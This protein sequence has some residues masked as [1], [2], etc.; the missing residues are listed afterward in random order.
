MIVVDEEG[1][2]R[3]IAMDEETNV[4]DASLAEEVSATSAGDSPVAKRGEYGVDASKF[5][6]FS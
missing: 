4:L 6:S 1:G 2:G 3:A 5:F